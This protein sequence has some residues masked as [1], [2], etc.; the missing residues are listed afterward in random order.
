MN[1]NAV[2]AVGAGLG[3][4]LGLISIATLSWAL[5]E[6]HRRQKEAAKAMQAIEDVQKSEYENATVFR[7]QFSGQITELRHDREP[8]ELY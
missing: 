5:W 2:V 7:P 3:V 8:V 1:S 6:R 4:A